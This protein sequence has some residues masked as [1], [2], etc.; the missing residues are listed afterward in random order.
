MRKLAFVVL[1]A[2]WGV[3]AFGA[4][5]DSA[6][7]KAVMQS[8]AATLGATTKALAASDWEAVADGFIQFSQN[9]K[10]MRAFTPPKGD[11]QEWARIW[12]DFLFAAY[13]GVGAAGARDAVKAK[14]LLDQI[15]GD[16]N[17]GHSQFRG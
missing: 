3:L 15:T 10:K 4:D 14:A 12:E 9:A 16:R 1:F 17:T 2:V 5:Y 6:A 8:N 11:A 7:V 13:Q